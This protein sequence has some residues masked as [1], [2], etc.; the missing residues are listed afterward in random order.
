MLSNSI[1]CRQAELAVMMLWSLPKQYWTAGH[2]C[3]LQIRTSS[4]YVFR[5]SLCT[6]AMAWQGES[7]P[8]NCRTQ[9]RVPNNT[10]NLVGNWFSWERQEQAIIYLPHKSSRGGWNDLSSLF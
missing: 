10:L 8:Y 5:I 6:V 2:S 1:I 7:C 4:S 9:A 3:S